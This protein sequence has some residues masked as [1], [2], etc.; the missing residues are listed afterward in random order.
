MDGNTWTC[1]GD[2][3]LAPDGSLVLPE[4]PAIPGI[5]RMDLLAPDGIHTVGLNEMPDISEATTVETAE[6]RAM[7]ADMGAQ[8]RK[9]YTIR[10]S[11]L[12]TFNASVA[13]GRPLELNT[14]NR[15]ETVMSLVNRRAEAVGEW[16]IPQPPSPRGVE[17]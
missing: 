10:F 7:L 6:D 16:D 17:P 5:Y 15:R 4:L 1:A 3:T 11:Y 8:I 13:G 2:A 9:G 12:D 14:K